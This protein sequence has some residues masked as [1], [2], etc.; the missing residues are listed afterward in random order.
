MKTGLVWLALGTLCSLSH[1]QTGQTY[2]ENTGEMTDAVNIINDGVSPNDAI[3]P[4][5]I[6]MRDASAESRDIWLELG[7]TAWNAD[8]SHYV[9]YLP[10]DYQ[11]TSTIDGIM[12]DGTDYSIQIDVWD[13]YSSED[14]IEFAN[15]EDLDAITELSAAVAHCNGRITTQFGEIEV[16]GFYIE[17]EDGENRIA[18]YIPYWRYDSNRTFFG[19][20]PGP[21]FAST[22][23]PYC[24][25]CALEA[26][27]EQAYDTAGECGL[28]QLGKVAA[29][30]GAMLRGA[31]LS[32]LSTCFWAIREAADCDD[33]LVD[34]I[35]NCLN[36]HASSWYLC[37]DGY[38]HY[39]L[40]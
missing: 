37:N 23:P 9:A 15:P 18:N 3:E 10:E 4:L 31:W 5:P 21:S 35:E 1:A 32:G 34:D 13:F 40:N 33:Q 2:P 16:F 22:N 28:R 26:C 11:S 30:G 17:Y 6:S 38:Y 25:G 29:A 39:E 8:Q 36:Q 24:S 20:T 19:N 7:Q 12:S 27:L 14:L